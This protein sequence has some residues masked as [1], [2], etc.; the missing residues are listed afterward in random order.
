MPLGQGF[1]DIQGVLV[2]LFCLVDPVGLPVQ[3]CQMQVA[4]G[5]L[6]LVLDDSGVL[7]GQG[8]ADSQGLPVSSL[9]LLVPAGTPVH[10]AQVVVA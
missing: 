4:R 8:L 5:E 2:G 9:R 1:L 10:V 7:L 3:G 6:C